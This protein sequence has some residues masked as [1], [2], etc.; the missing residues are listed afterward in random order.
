[1]KLKVY[2]G[3]NM[4][5]KFLTYLLFPVLLASQ[6]IYSEDDDVEEV[7]VTGSYIK[8]DREEIAVPVDVFDR[9]EY[10]NAGAPNMREVLRN[11]PAITGTI[12]QSEQFSDGGGTIVGLKN[13]N[14]RSL[15]I[16]RTLVLFNGKRIVTSSGTTKEGNAFVDVGNFPMIAMERIEVL[17]NG[18]AIAHGTDAMGGVFNFITRNKFEGFEAYARHDDMEASDGADE[19]AF[20]AGFSNGGTHLVFGAEWQNTN[21]VSIAG[22]PFVNHTGFNKAAGDW[23][24]G[25]SS[26]GNPGSFQTTPG[27]NLIGDPAC[28]T[29]LPIT[30]N[31]GAA[32]SFAGP[33]GYPYSKCG[34]NYVPF[35]NYVDPQERHKFFA[36]M[37]MEISDDVE[38]YAEAFHSQLRA[39]YVGSPSYP[40][41]NAGYF[42]VV[43]TNSPGYV[44]FAAN[45]LLALPATTQA[46]YNA[47][48]ASAGSV[49]WWGRSKAI[50]GPAAIFNNVND[51]SRW[52]VGAKGTLP[53]TELGFDASVTYSTMNN[54]YQYYDIITARF[55]N[56]VNGLGGTKCTRVAADAG[57][58]SKGCYYYNVFG[59]H[60]TAAP[61]SALHNSADEIDYITGDMGAE[62]R[63]SSLVFDFIVNG[64]L[65]WEIDN[66]AVAFAAGV[67]FRQDDGETKNY[68]DARCA[69]NKPCQPELHFLP[70]T[71]DSGNETKNY[72]LFGE[73]SLPVS[74]D[75]DVNLGVRYEDYGLDNITVPKISAL[76]RA[77]DT[78]SIRASY[79]EVFRSPILPTAIDTSLERVYGEYYEVQTPIPT[80]LQ[81]ESSENLNLGLL[82][83][84]VE[85][86]KVSLD[87]YSLELSDNIGKVSTTSPLAVY[88]CANGTSYSPPASAPPA[89]CQLVNITTNSINGD[90][91]ETDGID[92]QVMYDFDTSMGQAQIGVNGVSLLSYDIMTATGAYDAAGKYNTR[93]TG[94]PI[95][96]RTMPDLKMNFMASLMNGDHYAR[97]FVRYVSEYDVD[98]T[99]ANASSFAGHPVY[100]GKSVDSF[101]TLD[102]HYTYSA[103]ENTELTLSIVNVADEEPP[104]APHEQGYDAFAHSPLG[105]VTTAAIKYSF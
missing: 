105:R 59:S 1:M 93:A 80:A 4:K 67:Q 78:L 23:P 74:E 102:V 61:G 28:G 99:F 77:S 26:F 82:W 39:D 68:G 22:K 91:V 69:D 65:D 38:I 81:P 75:M 84:P 10:N 46:A 48:A 13:V 19:A 55:N 25:S 53:G 56:A 66:N 101:V 90:G 57:D 9:G 97:A 76:Y 5:I 71:Y 2:R 8:T 18:G 6:F 72:G 17:K 85:G 63:K 43:P 79:E 49:Y 94:S 92:F 40:P 21:P 44:D 52:A 62:S 88:N 60:L 104:Y 96:V 64:D 103:M 58:A 45:G 14:I 100:D 89:G 51:T 20:I 32:P 47:R 54:H 73:L 36:M 7:V 35:G 87:Y 98:S 95:R 33:P 3:E 30:G 70:M 24:L 42:T 12:N 29:T 31:A 83:S 27:A 41:T 16:P 15:G 37:T 34:Y 86:L 11:M 50:E